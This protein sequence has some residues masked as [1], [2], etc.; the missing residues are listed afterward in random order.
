MDKINLYDTEITSRCKKV[1]NQFGEKR[2]QNF[3]ILQE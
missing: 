3:A 1:E 2:G